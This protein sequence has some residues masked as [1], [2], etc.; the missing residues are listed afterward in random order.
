MDA[1]PGVDLTRVLGEMRE[2]YEAMA[3]KNRRDAEAWFFSKT[4]ELNKEVASDTEMIETS[5]TEI[6]DLRRT[7]Q[8]LELELQSQLSM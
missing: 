4:E 7:M 1:A 3:E 6:T 8:G 5:K 2:Q